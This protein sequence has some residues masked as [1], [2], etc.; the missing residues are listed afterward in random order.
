MI[1]FVRIFSIF[2]RYFISNSKLYRKIRKLFNFNQ[3]KT[4]FEGFKENSFLNAEFG[5]SDITNMQ[6]HVI[7]LV[8]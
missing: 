8:K 5:D 4:T 1:L 3:F 7:T 2:F 6:Y